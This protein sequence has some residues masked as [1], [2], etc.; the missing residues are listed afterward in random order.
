MNAFKK[1]LLAAAVGCCTPLANAHT[2]SP[3]YL[4]ASHAPAGV[5]ADHLHAEG[6]WMFGYRVMR[7][8]YSDIYHGSD[9]VG[10][11]EVAM[12]GYSMMPTS[13]TMEM[14]MLDIM[15]AVSDDLTLML[16]PQ[17]MTMDMAME[18]VGSGHG[19]MDSMHEG[20]HDHSVS[21]VGDTILG[22]LFRIADTQ[23]YRL[24]ATLAISSP[25]GSVEEKNADGTFT[26][27]GMQLGSGTWDLLPSLT[28][29]S[30]LERLSWGA[31][32]SA[33]LPLEDENDSGFAFG[34]R[35]GATAWSAYRIADWA[36]L[37]ARLEYAKEGDINGHY[38][39]PHNHSSPP[40]LQENYGGEFVDCGI[41]VNFVAQRG[42]L[43][44]VRLGL[45][46]VGSISAN[47]NGYQ[48]AREDGL[49]MSLSYAF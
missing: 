7:E 24:H 4:P 26:H 43:A 28:Y 42:A 23:G 21:G 10:A 22:G 27:Y 37:S 20:G 17:Y 32:V 31:Q 6:E 46:W 16:M 8:E 39:G 36:S 41:G 45:E 30:R 34:E 25:T 14:H 47:Y 11:M 38:N 15:Y 1:T 44:G 48:L 18:M 29:T 9:E 13:M 2:E 33:R 3:V 40:D 35:Y 49:N 19:H 5:M 12:A